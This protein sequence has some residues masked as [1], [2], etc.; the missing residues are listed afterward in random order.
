MNKYIKKI[1]IIYYFFRTK[2]LRF[3]SRK[4]LKRWQKKKFLWFK[5]NILIN[6]PY[7]SEYLNKPFEQWP[8]INK[9]IHMTNF[10]SINTQSIDRDKALSIAIQSENDRNF[11]PKYNDFSI[12]LSSG[13]SGSRG[14]FVASEQEQAEWAGTILAKML[15]GGIYRQRIAFFLRANNNLYETV[16]SYL[17]KFC[18]YDLLNPIK[19]HLIN[20]QDYQPTILVAP[21]QVLK[22]LAKYQGAGL[23]ISPKKIISVAE[24]LTDEDR[25]YIEGVFK[26]HIE[27]IY[28][29]TEGFLAHTCKHGKLHLN[30]DIVIIEKE[31]LDKESGRFIPIITDFR[32]ETQPVIRYRLDDI[33]IKDKKPCDCGSP[34]TVLSSIEG[35]CDD[36]L[37]MED[38]KNNSVL[39]YPDFVRNA[40]I[41]SCSEIDEYEVKQIS[42]QMI[43]I[44][45]SPFNEKVCEN[46][47]N[48]L[49][50]LFEKFNVKVPLFEFK[51]YVSTSS[52]NKKRRVQGVK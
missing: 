6:S 14:L 27:Q 7:Y 5:N 34:C 48:A 22:E 43:N 36:A 20:L 26:L 30:E 9:K 40:I 23:N 41:S 4:D 39:I 3:A 49:N 47:K 29:C 21:A 18:F 1:Y 25:E 13:T 32:R 50:K 33:L 45:I 42:K 15:P 38:K 37:K 16:G 11:I 35:R 28:Q 8:I 10:N 46:I 12:G 2:V 31:W 44:F 19:N 52:L 17:I 51:P 24:V